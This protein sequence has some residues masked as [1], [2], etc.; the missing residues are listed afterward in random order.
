MSLPI[1]YLESI[2]KNDFEKLSEIQKNLK[3][4][5]VEEKEHKNVIS[6]DTININGEDVSINQLVDFWVEQHRILEQAKKILKEQ[7]NEDKKTRE[8]HR[9]IAARSTFPYKESNKTKLSSK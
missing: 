8:T 7:P 4:D 3:K 2:L 9:K 6:V 5:P 1:T